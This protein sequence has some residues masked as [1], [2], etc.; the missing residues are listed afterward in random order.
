MKTLGKTC[1]CCKVEK[2]LS[3]FSKGNKYKGKQYLNSYCKSCSKEKKAE[4]VSDPAVRN[5]Y[6]NSNRRSYLLRTY[7]ITLEEYQEM[8]DSQGGN[9]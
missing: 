1:A 9:L 5:K 3:E 2:S 4:Y 7:G 8:L 6:E